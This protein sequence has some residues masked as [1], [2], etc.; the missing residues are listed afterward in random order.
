MLCNN[1]LYILQQIWHFIQLNIFLIKSKIYKNIDT[2]QGGFF[3]HES[4]L[5]VTIKNFIPQYTLCQFSLVT[6]T[7]KLNTNTSCRN[8]VSRHIPM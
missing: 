4:K 7:L 6:V 5:K 1:N 2:R 8:R 3:S